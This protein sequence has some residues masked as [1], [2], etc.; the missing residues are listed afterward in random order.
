MIELLPQSDGRT[1]GVRVSGTVTKEE[2][3]RLRDLMKVEIEQHDK[4]RMLVQLD[5]WSG[6]EPRVFWEDLKF[7][8]SHIKSFEKFA[9][10][11]DRQ[12]Q[13]SW[14]K[15]MRPVIPGEQRHFEPDQI[16]D[17]WN[18]LREDPQ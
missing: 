14:L 9:L 5:D 4:I 2:Y 1:L 10:V 13:E 11:G 16:D 18:W 12:W 17:A 15:V 7:S 8:L 3:A 6:M